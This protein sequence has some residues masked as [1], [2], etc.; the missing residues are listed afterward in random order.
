ML[1]ILIVCQVIMR[2]CENT[3]LLSLTNGYLVRNNAEM[4]KMRTILSKLMESHGHTAYDVHKKTGVQPSTLY[5]YFASDRIDLKA[6]TVKKLATLYG[7]T[8]SQL[9]GDVPIDGMEIQA[10]KPELKELL[11]RD[12]YQLVANLTR[13]NPAARAILHSLAQMLVAEQEAEYHHDPAE[14]RQRD[15]YPN[16]QM[17]VGER[18]HKSSLT[19]K[20]R[21]PLEVRRYAK[22]THSA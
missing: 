2:M 15:V 1:R 16:P 8:E 19:K 21:I 10:E 13:M 6:A 18:R 11:P 22:S 17:R 3:Q 7:L 12:E 9:R 5:R 20:R 4:S 14:R